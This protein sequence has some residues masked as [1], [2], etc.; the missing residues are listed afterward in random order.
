VLGEDAQQL[1]L[2]G[3]E[4]DRSLTER[5]LV[6]REVDAQRSEPQRVRVP[7][8]HERRGCAAQHRLDARDDLR[9][10]RG[11]DDVVIGAEPQPAQLVAVVATRG[12]KQQRQVGR[13]AH[14]PAE[15]EA[16]CGGEHDV[17]HRADDLA[18]VEDGQRRLG[19]AGDEDAEAGVVEEVAQ[20]GRDLGLILH[21]QHRPWHRR[22]V[23]HAH[24]DP[25]RFSQTLR[26]ACAESSSAASCMDVMSNDRKEALR[27]DD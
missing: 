13:L 3:G 25:L 22:I 2:A 24:K 17:H 19:I 14:P 21:D 18:H 12:E 10:R 16:R 20:K 7:V 26:R 23:V 1:E 9:G 4:A 8:A 27:W 15:V 6:R 5:H 11:L